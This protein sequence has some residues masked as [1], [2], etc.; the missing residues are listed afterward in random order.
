MKMKLSR[1]SSSWVDLTPEVIT[2]RLRSCWRVYHVQ[3]L[4]P[5]CFLLI[6]RLGLTHPGG[7]CRFGVG[8]LEY[9][10]ANGFMLC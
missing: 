7:G 2:A 5:V 1:V 8:L 4:S 10:Y 6:W 9:F 3:V